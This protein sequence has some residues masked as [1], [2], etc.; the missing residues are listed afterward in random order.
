[1]KQLSSDLIVAK[2][3]W[4]QESPWLW[5]LEIERDD[6]WMLEYQSQ[7]TRFKDGATLTGGWGGGTASIVV[8]VETR[9][10]DGEPFSGFLILENT[11]GDSF[12]S[13]EPISDDSGGAGYSVGGVDTSTDDPVIARL[14]RDNSRIFYS[15][16]SVYYHP[17]PFSVGTASF[18]KNQFRGIDITFSNALGAVESFTRKA[19]GLLKATATVKIV[20]KGDLAEAPVFEQSYTVKKAS[21]NNQ[22]VSFTCGQENFLLRGFPRYRYSRK[23]CRWRFKSDSCGYSGAASTCSRT[24]D[25]CIASSNTSRFG[26]F[27]AIPG[28]AF[29]G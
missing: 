25:G 1:M 22:H 4:R 18:A 11:G 8:N 14:V 10:I 24:I 28:S 2:N 16:E 17:L 19:D 27:P 15:Y 9:G 29:S 3:A 21:V 23:R 5:L 6:W 7:S 26:G 12:A 13:G 20:W